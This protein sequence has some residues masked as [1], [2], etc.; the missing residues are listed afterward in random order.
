MLGNEAQAHSWELKVYLKASECRR[1]RH[2]G[3]QPSAPILA[4]LLGWVVNGGTT[5]SWDLRKGCKQTIYFLVVREWTG[6]GFRGRDSLGLGTL[7]RGAT[8]C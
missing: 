7:N 8:Q 5:A 6:L 2:L 4:S 1:K 3:W